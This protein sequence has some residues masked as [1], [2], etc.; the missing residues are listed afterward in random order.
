[1]L[2]NT[3]VAEKGPAGALAQY[4]TQ[5]TLSPRDPGGLRRQAILLQTA[6]M[7]VVDCDGYILAETSYE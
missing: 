7:S 2:Y 6:P 3:I 1:M 4:F 5:R